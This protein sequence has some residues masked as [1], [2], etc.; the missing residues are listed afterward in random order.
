MK[1]LLF[2]LRWSGRDLRDRWLLVLAI[3]ATIALGT[4]L[5]GSLESMG[6]WRKDASTQS[7]ALLRAHDVRLYLADGSF[8]T[9]DQL[10]ALV[11]RIPHAS[12]VLGAEERLVMATRVN[13]STA[14]QTIVVPGQLVGMSVGDP[15]VDRLDVKIGRSLTDE[16]SSQA[17]AELEYHFGA[18]YGLPVPGSVT[19]GDGHTLEVVG[20][21]LSAD[22]LVVISPMGDFMAEA[23]YAVVFVPLATAGDLVGNPGMANEL[24]V[25]LSDPSLA[26]VVRDE[27][28]AAAGVQLPDLGAA[29]VA[30]SD[31]PV[32][33][34]LERDA[35]NDQS[36]FAMFAALML[37]G[38]AFAAFN[39]TSRIVE[40]QRRQ[41]GIG[42]ALG[43]PARTLAI[44][45]LAVAAEIAVFGVVL[46]VAVGMLVDAAM[47]AVFKSMMPMPVF[48]TPFRPE[49]FARAAVVGFVLPFAASVYP[50]WRAVRARPVDAIR[51]GYLAA[52]RPGL[53]RL[54][55]RLPLPS[56]LRVPL[57][58]VLR[59]PRR[60]ALTAFGIA[61]AVTMLVGTIGMLD[62]FDVGMNRGQAEMVGGSP[63]RIAV[64]LAA[65]L[66][67][68]T[69]RAE[70]GGVPGAGRVDTVLRLPATA[71]AKNGSHDPIDIQLDVLNLTDN[72]WR[73]SVAEGRLPSGPGEAMLSERAAADLGLRPGDRFLLRHPVRLS[74]AAVSM[75]ETEVTL[76]GTN[77]S[78][79]RPT[80]YM[81]SSGASLFEMEGLANRA[82][83]VPAAGADPDALRRTLFALP[84]VVTAQ[85]I[86]AIVRSMRD[87][88]AQ[89]TDILSVVAFI[90]LLLAFLVAYNSATISQDERTREVAT[91]LAFGLPVRRVMA[92]AMVESG[93][94]G[95]IGTVAGV[96]GGYGALIWLTYGLLPT[97]M[98]EFALD[99][100]I[101]AGTV[102]IAIGLGVV[103]VALAPLLTWRRLTRMNLPAT[104]RVVE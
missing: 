19:V 5:Y 67:V 104:L 36:F 63:D 14:D 50:V 101:S 75:V 18:H 66:P 61:A 46:G 12:A 93:L 23:N 89:F 97:S 11:D 35:S 84:G 9:P 57:S 68:E 28:A 4:G 21:A 73:A 33:R 31:E 53:A 60:T 24:V 69:V 78:P 13:A 100:S 8:A 77:P 42:L 51:T 47:Q 41:V 81:D 83:V 22:H 71:A 55:R 38:A 79:L 102:L 52:R 34:W 90:A 1:R 82:T 95:S 17:R 94:I 39:L 40:A 65:P 58:N 44:R 15:S 98:P 91:M 49:V 16:D 45:P 29:A 30:A 72:A 70:I 85:R 6:G 25:R 99:P 96:A 54:A 3:A 37:A 64:D 48:E 62:T 10:R 27:L 103:A 32:R 87:L 86:D 74:A 2:W 76:A 80:A 20:Q 56:W 92:S 88:V 43:L 59:T 7:L 26:P